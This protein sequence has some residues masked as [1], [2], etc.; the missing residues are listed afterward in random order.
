MSVF[1]DLVADMDA[2]IF[3]ALTDDVTING[4]LVKGMFSAPWL[5]PRI[6][7][8]HTGIIEPQLV[9]RDADAAGVEKGDPV[10][11]NGGSYGVVNI[12]PDGTGVT[13]LVL[14]PTT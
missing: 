14:R 5:E 4:T 6:G 3:D 1:R 2:A 11:A 8:L 9:V 10:V 7:H 13:V 12:E